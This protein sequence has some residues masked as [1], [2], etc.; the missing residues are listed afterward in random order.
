MSVFKVCEAVGIENF[1]LNLL[2][3]IVC[4]CQRSAPVILGRAQVYS[5][6]FCVPDCRCFISL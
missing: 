5:F 3:K 1:T 4:D 2:Q 6:H